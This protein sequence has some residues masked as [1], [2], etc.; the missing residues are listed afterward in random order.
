MKF[1]M[2][3]SL[4]LSLSAGLLNAQGGPPFAVAGFSCPDPCT[5]AWT[6][7]SQLKTVTCS[8][9]P[10]CS[11]LVIVYFDYRA[12]CQGGLDIRVTGWKPAFPNMGYEYCM[13]N[14]GI[15]GMLAKLF[16]LIAENPPAG[17]P[18]LGTDQD[19]CRDVVQF[20]AAHCYGYHWPVEDPP[21]WFACDGSS[22]CKA[23]YEICKVNSSGRQYRV[24]PRLS[25]SNPMVGACQP[26][27][28]TGGSANWCELVCGTLWPELDGF[29]GERAND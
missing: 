24:G 17:S 23:T 4:S 21:Y 2:L 3:L 28:S 26:D 18:P 5:T 15:S 25:M 16:V 10:A 29:A 19:P 13:A 7:T 9:N 1:V 12:G 22:C 14:C 8:G 27:P 11:A 6:S 20:Y